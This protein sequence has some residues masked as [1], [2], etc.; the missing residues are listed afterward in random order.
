M[1]VCVCEYRK[2]WLVGFNGISTPVGYLIPKPVFKYTK[3]L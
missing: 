1:C 2:S 3:Y